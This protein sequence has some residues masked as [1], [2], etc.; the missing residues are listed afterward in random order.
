MERMKSFFVRIFI[1]NK[2]LFKKPLFLAVLLLV[3]TLVFAVSIVDKSEGGALSVAIAAQDSGDELASYVMAELQNSSRLV[4]FTVCDTPDEAYELV[5]SGEVD[6]AWIFHADLENKIDKFTQSMHN[7]N[8]VVTVVQREDTVLLHLSREKLYAALYPHEAYMLYKNYVASELPEIYGQVGQ[9]LR[10]YYDR[11]DAP[12]EDLFQFSYL[13]PNESTADAENMS[14]LLAPM[15]GLLSVLIILGGLAAAMF[16]MQDEAEGKFFRIPISRRYALAV[17]YHFI[18]VLD[19]AVAA[20]V[21]ILVSGIAVSLLREVV[22]ML[23]YAVLSTAFCVAVGLVCGRASRLGALI[24]AIIIAMIAVCPV[25]FN[26][27]GASMLLYLLPPF[28]YLNAVHSVGFI[29]PMLIYTAILLLIGF[30]VYKIRAR[31]AVK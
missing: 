23:I 29:L 27:M 4:S 28:Y 19:I 10:E 20:L 24:P 9:G 12:G 7:K 31:V 13:D 22:L 5:K 15:R 2:R 16:Y 6:S 14:Y 18:A 17:V 30:A 11:I 26:T 3:P 21:A 8:A 25:F 1:L